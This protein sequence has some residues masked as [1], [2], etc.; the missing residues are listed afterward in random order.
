[1]HCWKPKMSCI[2]STCPTDQ[3]QKGQNA[4]H[5]QT[6]S[7]PEQSQADTDSN[8]DAGMCDAEN[9]AI[10]PPAE[11]SGARQKLMSDNFKDCAKRANDFMPSAITLLRTLRCTKASSH[12]CEATMRWKRESQVLLHPGES[13]LA[14]SPHCVGCEQVHRKPKERCNRPHGF[15]IKT[16]IVLPG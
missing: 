16:E 13:P 10:L 9:D 14:K 1:M 12:T 7:Q 4:C 5:C 8:V 11:E 2:I 6:Q 3:G 15:G